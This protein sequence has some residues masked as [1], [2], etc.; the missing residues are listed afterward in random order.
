MYLIHTYYNNV[1]LYECS[2]HMSV[3]VWGGGG[4]AAT[5]INPLHPQ[6]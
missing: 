5:A 6:W 1:G 2:V 4:G 3:C